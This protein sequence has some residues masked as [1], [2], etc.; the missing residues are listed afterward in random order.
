VKGLRQLRVKC[1]AFGGILKL[2]KTNMTKQF[3]TR[4]FLNWITNNS[5][6]EINQIGCIVDKD[7]STFTVIYNEKQAQ[8]DYF[9]KYQFECKIKNELLV[10]LKKVH[11]HALYKISEED[12]RPTHLPYEMFDEVEN[13]IKACEG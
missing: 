3:N 8:A 12:D 6:H 13:M 9:E 2:K 7:G 11:Q 1:S 5:I 4:D 10:L